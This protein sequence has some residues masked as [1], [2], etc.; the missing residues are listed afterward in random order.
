L[1][2]RPQRSFSAGGY[3]ALYATG[4]ITPTEQLSLVPSMSQFRKYQ[5]PSKTQTDGRTKV[6]TPEIEFGAF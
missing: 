6:Q 1:R 2:D 3:E 4:I 5:T